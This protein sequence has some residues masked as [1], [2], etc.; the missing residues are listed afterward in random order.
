MNT[1]KKLHPN[2]IPYWKLSQGIWS[3]VQIVISIIPA[4]TNWLWLHSWNWLLY[5]SLFL[6]VFIIVKRIHFV[7]RGVHVRYS[8]RSYRLTEDEIT[9]HYGSIWSHASTVIP[10][11]RIQHVDKEQGIIAKRFG[12]SELELHTAG[13]FHYIVGLQ[14]E[15]AEIV[16]KQ[17]ITFAKIGD[18][19]AYRD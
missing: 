10:M 18:A 13:E 9:I 3:V 15:D 5:V 7:Y 12:L 4:G 1:E 2:V 8:R 6:I 19:D 16:R 14:D 11:S 17:V